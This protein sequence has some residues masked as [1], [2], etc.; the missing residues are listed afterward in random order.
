M[1]VRQAAPRSIGELHRIKVRGKAQL[2]V[3]A[4]RGHRQERRD[5]DARNAQRLDEM[6]EHGVELRRL[7]LILREC[8]RRGLV[9]VLIRAR[10]QCPR[11]L[12]RR[13]QFHLLHLLRV[14]L[15]GLLR[16]LLK[17]RVEVRA[18]RALCDDALTV[19]LRHRECAVE[20]VAEV[21]R[22][23]GVDAPDQRIARDVAVLSERDLAQEEVAHGIRAELLNE[24]NRVDDVAD[25]LRHLRAVHDEPAVPIDLFR[26]VKAERHEHAAPDDRMEAHDLLADEMH[27]CGPVF[28]ELFLVMQIADR[29]KVVRKRVEPDVD[30]VL[31]VE[32]HGDA[33]VERGARNA[34]VLKPLLNEG[35]HFVAA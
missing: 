3:N 15:D 21:V 7:R 31:R 26:Q 20:E 30:D 35:N 34:E 27:V 6:I 24:R 1:A 32:R 5:E 14:G 13:R 29:R 8:P 23:I 4:A 28:A 11:R 10:D 18:P 2:S 19:L 16:H 17:C 25:G 22:E 9:D 33:P 12:D